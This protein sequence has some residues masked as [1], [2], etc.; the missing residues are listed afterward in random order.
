MNYIDWIM[1]NTKVP[2]Y[3]IRLTYM[4]TPAKDKFT[5]FDHD[6]LLNIMLSKYSA[7]QSWQKV[8]DSY[9][10]KGLDKMIEEVNAKAKE[11]GIE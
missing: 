8:V 5:V 4:S 3:D 9:K 10:A 7:E 1:N 11:E 6:D 2:D